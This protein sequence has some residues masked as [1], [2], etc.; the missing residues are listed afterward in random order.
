[1]ESKG[2]GASAFIRDTGGNGESWSNVGSQGK[3]YENKECFYS[4]D[5]DRLFSPHVSSVVILQGVTLFSGD[6]VACLQKKS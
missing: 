6:L 2:N 1:M 5:L 4:L 3:V